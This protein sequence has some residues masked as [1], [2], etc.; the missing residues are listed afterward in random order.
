MI[1]RQDKGNVILTTRGI[2]LKEI[3]STGRQTSHHYSGIGFAGGH[4]IGIQEN[5]IVNRFRFQYLNFTERIQR[6][7]I[8]LTR[9]GSWFTNIFRCQVKIGAQ[10]RQ[11]DGLWIPQGDTSNIGKNQVLGCFDTDTL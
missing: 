6:L 9:L 2:D 10:I 3:G 11:N 7:Q 5:S 8:C 1:T 4:D